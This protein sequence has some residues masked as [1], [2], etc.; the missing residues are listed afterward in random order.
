MKFPRRGGILIVVTLVT[1]LGLSSHTQAGEGTDE[2][3]TL[4]AVTTLPGDQEPTCSKG[5]ETAIGLQAS[6][7]FE[8]MLAGLKIHIGDVALTPKFGFFLQS[9]K[10]RAGNVS[11]V[12]FGMGFDYYF[13]KGKKARPYVGGDFLVYLPHAPGSGTD[14]WCV[15]S[16]HVGA[17]YWLNTSFSI[18]A[19]L[20]L[21]FGIGDSFYT[22]T[23]I[24]IFEKSDFSFGTNG[25]IHVTYYF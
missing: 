19:N 3:G 11:N 5:S 18:G 22:P 1:L 12:V 24:G 10:D 17:E 23:T 13:G 2:E 20:G 25:L 9:L 14:V 21:Q 7:N 4:E 15:L 8:E 6:T 16:P